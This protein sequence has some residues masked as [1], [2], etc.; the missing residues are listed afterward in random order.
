VRILFLLWGSHYLSVHSLQ[1]D[2]FSTPNSGSVFQLVCEPLTPTLSPEGI[3]TEHYSTQL[4]DP[5]TAT[6]NNLHLGP[7]A[8]PHCI[9]TETRIDSLH[10]SKPQHSFL[11]R[12]A[13][14]S[15]HSQKKCHLCLPKEPNLWPDVTPCKWS[16]R[17]KWNKRMVSKKKTYDCLIVATVVRRQ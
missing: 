8:S 10:T 5:F 13:R 4:P 3:F 15:A 16:Y 12:P 7:C 17:S 9:H 1:V 2:Y 6:V 11:H 14:Q